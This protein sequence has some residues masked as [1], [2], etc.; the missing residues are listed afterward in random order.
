MLEQLLINKIPEG[1]FQR[2]YDKIGLVLNREQGFQ[3]FGALVEVFFHSETASYCVVKE[4][5]SGL[6]LDEL[7]ALARDSKEPIDEK[8]IANL[9]FKVFPVYR[10]SSA[11]NSGRRGRYA[12][13]LPGKRPHLP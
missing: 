9:F 6:P 11:G 8:L 13:A 3:A 7:L 4:E 2:L 1:A 12:K 10:A 5:P